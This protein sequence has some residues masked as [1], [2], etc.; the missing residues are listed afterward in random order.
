MSQ[1]IPW[2]QQYE[3]HV[4]DVDHQH[5]ELF[6][7]LN[8]LLDATWDGKGQDF[9]KQALDFMAN[10]T[11]NHFATEESYMRRYGYLGYAE[12]KKAHDELTA[13]VTG[14][15]AVCEKKGISTDLLV[16]VILR[17]GN[18][19]KDHIRDMDQ[20]LGQFIRTAAATPPDALAP[21][22]KYV[23]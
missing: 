7:M 16:S 14:F 8:G 3:V 20:A 5:R 23:A 22:R 4:P 12:H 9:M 10:Y 18:W 11:I 15:I 6:R 19:T 1:L 13:E 17:L 21:L 2:L